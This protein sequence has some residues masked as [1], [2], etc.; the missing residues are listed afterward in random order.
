VIADGA[1]DAF[2]FAR[3]AER[4]IRGEHA[5]VLFGGS[6]TDFRREVVPVVEAAN[7]LLVY[8]HAYEGLEQSPNVV[9]TGP[10]P[11]QQM[12][13][14]VHW[15]MSK[16]SARSF[17]LIG[18]DSATARC[19]S[20]IVS[21]QLVGLGAEQVGNAHLGA[22]DDVE[23]T[24][25]EI[26]DRKPDVIL[27]TL[28]GAPGIALLRALR[29]ASIGLPETAVVHWAIAPET[30]DTLPRDDMVDTF[31][32]TTTMEHVGNAPEPAEQGARLQSSVGSAPSPAVGESSAFHN[33][34]SIA[35]WAQA[36]REAGTT[37]PVRVRQSLIHQGL[38]TPH[39]IITVD[40]LTQHTWLAVSIA[41]VTAA[42]G[43]EPVWWTG[44]QAQ[45]PVPFPIS[46]SREVWEQLVADTFRPHQGTAAAAPSPF[47]SER[48]ARLP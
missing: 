8:P 40:P 18:G 22:T 13:A 29:G 2:M 35:L 31:V 41:R 26:A 37:D 25:R 43:L 33:C 32:V 15:C 28:S 17:F 24:V 46:R 48:G 6:T 42:G 14:A 5:C 36:V 21:D 7:H 27:T 20:A 19:V 45:R 1:T 34:P 30:L 4:L 10:L 12:P 11:N 16:R 47:D 23:A 38:G 9:Y 44:K 3:E 39:G